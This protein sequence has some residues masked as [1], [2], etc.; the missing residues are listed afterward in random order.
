MEVKT[1]SQEQV[2]LSSTAEKKLVTTENF[3]HATPPV[4]VDKA[5]PGN[6]NPALLAGS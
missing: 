6:S 3:N 1:K 4:V 2:K 5:L